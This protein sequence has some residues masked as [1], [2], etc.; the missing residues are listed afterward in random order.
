MN[1]L[2]LH[3]EFSNLSVSLTD[4]IG[5]FSPEKFSLG[6]WLF[7]RLDKKSNE[8]R[9]LTQKLIDKFDEIS[10]EEAQP[11]EGILFRQPII[12]MMKEVKITAASDSEEIILDKYTS[13]I[14]NFYNSIYLLSDF[15]EAFAQYLDDGGKAKLHTYM[16]LLH[17]YRE[18]RD[19][20]LEL[21]KEFE[22]IDLDSWE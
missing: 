16:Q 3:S 18:D 22:H 5:L 6:G 20:N 8:L 2:A 11:F 19:E 14:K 13:E 4:I 17:E 1:T 21:A 9:M 12:E 7:K 10:F 15:I